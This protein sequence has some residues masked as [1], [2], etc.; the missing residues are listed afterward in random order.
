MEAR[1]RQP[2]S[3]SPN[4][5]KGPWTAFFCCLF[6]VFVLSHHGIF[7]VLVPQPG[8][9][10]TLLAL[11]GGVLTTGLP[12]RSWHWAVIFSN[13]SSPV[14]LNNSVVYCNGRLS[15]I[16]LSDNNKCL[17][18]DTPAHCYSHPNSALRDGYI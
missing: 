6:T 10:P 5:E 9:E 2:S 12:G 18:N 15:C 1:A 14:S 13:P 11:K 17:I 8:M 4:V 3:T 7:G 16:Y